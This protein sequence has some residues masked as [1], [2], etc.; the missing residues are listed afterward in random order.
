MKKIK[1]TL[2]TAA[3]LPIIILLLSCNPVENDSTS[4][5][6]VYLESLMG[7][8]MNANP[9]NYVQSDVLY[10]DSATG[11]STIIADIATA[12][13]RAEM[14]SPALTTVPSQYNDV[15]IDRYVVS[16][17]RS[18]GRNQPGIDIP[19]SFEGYLSITL[20]VGNTESFGFVIVRE[21]AKAETPLI[22]LRD[23]RDAGVL[24]VTAK[25]EFYGHDMA[26]R[27]IKVVG[28]ISIF[29]ANYANE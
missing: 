2:K 12:T 28:Y 19:H 8:D 4:A 29:F 23:A 26:D 20:N 25:V 24:E 14:L 3:L 22:N 21:V 27:N 13:M 11:T 10:E 18:D 5:T 17:F 15:M 6:V 9:A 16:Y 7:V 1:V